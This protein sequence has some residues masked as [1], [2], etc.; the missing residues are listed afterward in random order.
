[1]KNEKHWDNIFIS[2][3]EEILGWFEKD[4][5]QTLKYLEKIENLN[6]KDV[7]ISG[8]GTSKIADKLALRDGKTVLNDISLEALNILKQRI[9]SKNVEFFHHDISKSFKKECDVWIDRAVL[10]FL[11]DEKDIE[12]YFI[13]LKQSL[14]KD[15]FLLLAQ[16]TKGTALECANL[17]LKQ[18]D[19]KEFS[20]H[21]GKSFKLLES[22]TFEFTMPSL[23][24]RD[25]IYAL[26]KKID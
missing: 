3:C 25:F 17:P 5:S 2:K 14:R 21:L 26:F 7:F 22:E 24:K 6:N 8:V 11:I 13:S 16:Y 9:K 19:L 23:E 1:M 12:N 10:H 4:F 18:Y 20:S 15:G